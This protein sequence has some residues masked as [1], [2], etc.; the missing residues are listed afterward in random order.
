MQN[1]MYNTIL[2]WLNKIKICM[3]AYNAKHLGKLLTVVIPGVLGGI[4]IWIWFKILPANMVYFL[5]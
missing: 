3:S 4:H 5:Y 1:K 2:F